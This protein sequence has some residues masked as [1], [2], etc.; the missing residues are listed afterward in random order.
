MAIGG[1]GITWEVAKR[2]YDHHM[3]HCPVYRDFVHYLGRSSPQSVD[4]IPF[5]PISAF[6][7]H[8]VQSGK[9]TADVVYRSSG[10][11]GV[12]SQHLLRSEEDYLE[13]TVTGFESFYG[14]L[15][16][17]T[18]LGL[19]PSYLERE[20]SSLISMLRHFMHLSESPYSTF[21]LHDHDSLLHSLKQCQQ[22]G[23]KTVLWGV[24]YALLDFL[25]KHK[26]K[27]PELIVV[28]TGGMK[29]R[30]A[31]MTKSDLHDVLRRGFGVP[32]IHSEY[33]MTELLSQAY[34][35]GGGVFYPAETMQVSCR[36]IDDPFAPVPLGKTGVICVADL[37]NWYSCGLI[38]TQDLGRLRADGGFEV[39]GR[40]DH[41]EARGC[42]LLIEEIAQ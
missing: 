9:W 16:S 25:E 35:Q 33:G 18:F 27:W 14:S 2:L 41:S 40:L 6:K 5:L 21:Y 26:I 22:E 24:A 12:Q 38:A 3:A 20:G 15:A 28:E 39:M 17:Y 30:R 13:N 10:T 29:G 1:S 23:R 8:A 36:A 19:L 11:G 4:E 7:H 37:A 31:E 34:S 32:A 42:N